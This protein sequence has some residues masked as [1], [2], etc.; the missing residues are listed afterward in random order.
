MNAPHTFHIPVMGL[1]FTVDSPLKVARFGITSVVSIVDDILIERMR[2]YYHT[3]FW[4]TFTPITN[5]EDDFRARR[6]TDYLNLLKRK[7]D[8]QLAE[9]RALPFLKG[10][11][12]Y[13]YF[14]MLPDESAVKILFKRML[15]AD[16]AEKTDLQ[17]V[18]KE[19]LQ[20]GSID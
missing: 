14:D 6:I 18:L 7:V 10:N 15:E 13:Q 4:G 1:A 9:M 3:K 2:E 8:E 11:D 5:K 20:P 12:L 16:G 17:R 19:E